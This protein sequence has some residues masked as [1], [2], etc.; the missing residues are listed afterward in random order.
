MINIRYCWM[1][2]F[3]TMSF[4]KKN[5]LYESFKMPI[6]SFFEKI[7]ERD[8]LLCN[9]FSRYYDQYFLENRYSRHK[10]HDYKYLIDQA[11]SDIEIYKPEL[12]HDVKDDKQFL[13]CY[14]LFNRYKQAQINP[15][16]NSLVRLS[17]YL[18]DTWK[19]FSGWFKSV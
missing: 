6:Q 5:N 10:R 3:F 12:L 11:L 9:D 4:S 1:F 13:I 14:G 16:N 19:I 17:F 7:N 15:Y 18:K 8:S 2:L